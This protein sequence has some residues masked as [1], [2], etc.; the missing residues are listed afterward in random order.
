MNNRDRQFFRLVD[1]VVNSLKVFLRALKNSNA[2]YG[3]DRH[4]FG[5]IVKFVY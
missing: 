2:Q 3:Q 1:F 5:L 4:F